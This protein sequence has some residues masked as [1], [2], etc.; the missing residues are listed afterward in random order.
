MNK[1]II[2][3]TLFIALA[4]VV[5]YGFISKTDAKPENAD[6]VTATETSEATEGINWITMEEAERVSKLDDKK[7]IVDVYT[8]WCGW[9]KRLDADTYSKAEV[10]EYIN[11]NY[12]AVKFNAEQKEP[13]TLGGR[14]YKF[15]AQG[16]RG[17]HELAAQMLNGRLSYPQ[18]VFFD[19]KLTI[20]TAVPGY[21]K[22]PEMMGFLTYFNENIYKTN[23]NAQ[24]YVNNYMKGR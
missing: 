22:A 24:E 19:D 8:D 6:A 2:F 14:T 12:H 3:A 21:R 9:C 17:Y 5:S 10:I 7:I 1:K 13:I 23:P 15:V 20:I 18:T 4:I 11:E 16:R